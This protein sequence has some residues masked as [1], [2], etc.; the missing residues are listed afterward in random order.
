[1][2]SATA[3]GLEYELTG[4]KDASVSSVRQE[5]KKMKQRDIRLMSDWAILWYL[6]KK[7]K[8]GLVTTAFIVY[9]SFSLFGTLIVGLIEGLFR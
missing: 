7:R 1:M 9:V 6:A 5:A 3:S 2:G 8:F 4:K